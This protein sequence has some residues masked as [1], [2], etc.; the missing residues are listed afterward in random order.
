VHQLETRPEAPAP[1]SPRT[2]AATPAGPAS[3]VLRMQRAVGNAQVQR[4][5]AQCAAVGPA[6]GD[7][8]GDV[9]AQI[10]A[11]RGGGQALDGAVRREMEGTLGTDLSGVRVHSDARADALSR[12]LSARA[13]TTGSDVFFRG[14]EYAPGSPAGRRLIA[15]ELTHVVQQGGAPV[16]RKLVVGP[17]NDPFEREADAVAAQVADAP[18]ALVDAGGT[19]RRAL[20]LDEEE[21]A[22][23]ATADGGLDLTAE[24]I[25]LL[26]TIPLNPLAYPMFVMRKAPAVVLA[27]LRRLPPEQVATVAGFMPMDTLLPLL[28]PVAIHLG[29]DHARHFFRGLGEEKIRRLSA[30]PEARSEM[31][32]ALRA[33]LRRAWPPGIGF[34]LDAGVGLTFGIPIHAAMDYLMYL[35]HASEGVFRFFRRVEGRLAVDVGGGAGVYAGQ[36]SRGKAAAA[37]G[38]PGFGVGAV[39][40]GNAEGGGKLALL[41]EFEFRVFESDP[42]FLSLLLAVTGT[43]TGGSGLAVGLLDR[44]A[45]ARVDPMHYNTR[46]KVDA[47]LYAQLAGE[48]S[49]GVRTA[50]AGTAPASAAPAAT[51]A[52][53]GG[54]GAGGTVPVGGEPAGTSPQEG[55][56]AARARGW[57]S[58]EEGAP[59][60]GSAPR[61]NWRR[62]VEKRWPAW[63]DALAQLN[64]ALNGRLFGQVGV[65]VDL[66]PR[67]AAGT[68]A[69]DRVGLADAEQVE[70]DVTAE[71]SAAAELTARM[72][73]IGSLF[74]GVGIEQAGGVKLSYVLT[75]NGAPGQRVRLEGYSVFH[76]RGELDYVSGVGEETEMRFRA[77][78]REGYLPDAP[79]SLAELVG[80]MGELRF[81]RRV[82][83]GGSLGEKLNRRLMGRDQL[84][85]L[86]RQK[87]ARALLKEKYR[88]TGHTLEGFVTFTLVLSREDAEAVLQVLKESVRQVL[89]TES[90]WRTVLG[91]LWRFLTTGEA[92]EYVLKVIDVI[93]HRS[94][95]T[96]F[97]MHLRGGVSGAMGAHV[98]ALAKVRAHLRGSALVFYDTDNIFEENPLSPMDLVEILRGKVP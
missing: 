95:I 15:H 88:E 45:G 1:A 29:P 50:P 41:Q 38:N 73:I 61:M 18:G 71:G 19:V 30:D 97:A 13:F 83:L 24:D 65:S 89:A 94:R 67:Q 14:G 74:P 6:G 36:R 5:L 66:R 9:E 58:W 63:S 64:V 44:L 81:R 62:M 34:T 37:A 31:E 54:S 82:Q 4:M 8:P 17:V 76:K 21:E 11:A 26:A 12:A 70:V 79:G 27:W 10:H 69:A 80:K 90:A 77:G 33:L 57:K 47:A 25:A 91:D 85:T 96:E 49:A 20:V 60:L 56:G 93:A 39:A 48:A 72:P 46:T 78:P 52:G 55:R 59:D 40:G 98:A 92:P 75:R 87:G 23:E 7:V 22:K 43:D 2:D 16:Q 51:P 28:G 68:R 42:A 35:W 3:A 84:T 53:G 86:R 32:T